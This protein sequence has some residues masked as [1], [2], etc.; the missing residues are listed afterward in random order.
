MSGSIYFVQECSTCGRNLQ[1]RVEYLGRMVV[2]QHCGV[3]F[4]AC[5]PGSDSVL[6]SEPSA[7]MLER[8]DELLRQSG[9]NL[10]NSA[11]HGRSTEV[12]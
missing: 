9:L 7:S 6:G 2:C 4:Q 10:Q 3:T 11:S 12:V 1:V 5:S 8:A